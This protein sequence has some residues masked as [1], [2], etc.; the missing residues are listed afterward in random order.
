VR[1]LT[2]LQLAA[3]RWW[4]GSAD[5]I[6][7]LVAGLEARGHRVLLGII[8]GDRFEAKARAAGLSPLRGLALTPRLLSPS[9]FRD[10]R[11]LRRLVA[12][13]GVDV[14]HAHHSHDHWLATL[15]RRGAGLVRTFHNARSVRR[16]WPARALYRRLDAAVAV[17]R[18]IRD[19]CLAAGIPPERI[20]TVPGLVDLRR[21]TPEADGAPV[22]RELGLGEAPV[23][24]CV[25]RLAPRRR[26]DLLIEAFG[27]VLAEMPRA[28]L[29]LVGKGERLQELQTLVRQR[30]LA[31]RIVFTGYR[32]R[33]L[34]QV[35]AAMDC[36]A[37]MGAGSDESCRAALEA[38]AAGLPVVARPV[39]ALPETVADGESGVLV[40]EDGPEAVA[41][42]L[43][44]VLRDPER[45]RRM[46]KE[47][48][49][50]AEALFTPER[51]VGLVEQ[52][53]RSVVERRR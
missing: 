15:A 43:L 50:R 3:N 14:I 37:L 49:R 7:R 26:H 41:A 33:D 25:A 9:V 40:L 4:T 22:R 30:G 27:R 29:L 42:A 35:L 1:P 45:A 32:D 47:G 8:P 2:I 21:F 18:E 52:L 13:E 48:R 24:G 44:R 34:P 53:Y 36:F 6:L 10:L 28:R 19:R 38:M 23:V 12:V 51:H 39:G 20:F 31:D 17:S 46:G 16:G 11:H 5:P